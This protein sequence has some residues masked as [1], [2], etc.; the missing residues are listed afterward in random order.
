[1]DDDNDL[2]FKE[3]EDQKIPSL[4]NFFDTDINLST[5]EKNDFDAKLKDISKNKNNPLNPTVPLVNSKLKSD[6]NSNRPKEF[7]NQSNPF[8]SDIS[9]ISLEFTTEKLSL[10]DD[11]KK[12][13]VSRVIQL[14]DEIKYLEVKD[15]KFT[16]DELKWQQFGD[17][18]VP[19]EFATA[20]REGKAHPF[21]QHLY[22]LHTQMDKKVRELVPNNIN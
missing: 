8:K 2:L 22:T 10:S 14:D 17:H 18:E 19:H 11:Y 20:L 15:I 1:M 7:T 13:E 3:I 21:S 16:M 12:E 5:I 6:S 4:N 9:S